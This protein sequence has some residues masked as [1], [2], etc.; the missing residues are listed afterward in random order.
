M[1]NSLSVWTVIFF[2]F[3][4]ACE[5]S[6]SSQDART[7][8]GQDQTIADGEDLG[9]EQ[10]LALQ[11]QSIADQE[12]PQDDMDTV[13]TPTAPMIEFCIQEGLASRTWQE[14][15]DDYLFGSIAGDF[16]VETIRG[17]WHLSEQWS[18]CESYVFFVYFPDLRVSSSGAWIGDQLWDSD[19]TGLL[20]GPKNTHYFF[21]SYEED[22]Q[23]RTDRMV[24]MHNRLIRSLNAGE[25]LP[26][27]RLH[28]VT[29]RVTEIEGSVGAFFS[30]YLAYVF[31]PN[32]V[33]DLEERGSI[34]PPLPFSFGIDRLQRWDSGGSL[35]EVVGRPMLWKMATYI[36]PFYNYISDVYDQALNDN[37]TEITLIDNRESERVLIKTVELPSAEEVAQYNTLEVDVS[38]TCPHR[39]VFA[40]SEWDRIARIE[41]CIDPECEARLEI[42]RWITPYWR[43]GERRWIWD[44][45]PFIGWLA[46]GGNQT[47]RIE[48]GPSWERPTERDVRVQLRLG[49]KENSKE[50]V[51]ALLAFTGGEFNETYN[52]RMPFRFTPP[53]NIDQVELVI[54]LS[55]HG[56]TAQDNCA[57][58]CDHQHHFTV[59]ETSLPT[60]KHEGMIGSSDGCAGSVTKGVSPGQFGNWAPERAFWC[61]GL[62]VE[63]IRIDLTEHV[64]L[65]TENTLQY[66]ATLGEEIE[67]RGGKITL[68]AYL[69]YSQQP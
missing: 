53:A 8:E 6:D 26:E 46:A 48:L 39:N 64:T 51:D 63:P 20:N 57:E 49:E 65:G 61:P 2:C 25:Q 67:P 33:V 1:L 5:S 69:V 14:P 7:T 37:A 24:D 10:D 15:Q 29:D 16:T 11:D 47:F 4:V 34:Q 41:Y 18:G 3:L 28:F 9:I 42:A 60:V 66:R 19:V 43:R 40:C 55:G 62:P 36:G 50:T 56:Q 27:R 22:L 68:N 32:S 17:P 13:S 38:V 23:V 12:F 45:T 58:W 35:D 31:D 21:L 52:D 59:N 54:L 30:D 44:A